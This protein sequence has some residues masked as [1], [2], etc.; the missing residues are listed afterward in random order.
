MKYLAILLLA[1]TALFAVTGYYTDEEV[2]GMSKIC[3]YDTYRGT[4]AITIE[5]YELCPMSVE[6]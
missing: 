4:M 3:Y 5:S 2:D 1:A 6:F